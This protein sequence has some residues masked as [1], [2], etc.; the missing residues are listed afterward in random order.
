MP[1]ANWFSGPLGPW[2][3]GTHCG[4]SNVI[5]PGR[6]GMLSLM[7]KICCDVFDASTFSTMAPG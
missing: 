3:A 4:Y 6:T 2:L 7:R 5:L 1:A